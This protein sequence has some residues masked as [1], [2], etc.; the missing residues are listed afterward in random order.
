MANEVAAD[1]HVGS[2]LAGY[3]IEALLGRGGM[4]VVYL[5][6][7]LA[8]GRMVAL[9]L[10][11]PE[12]SKDRRF[13]ERFR[14][15]SRLAASIDHPNVIPIY[16]AGEAEGQLFIAMRYVEGIDLKRL[17]D[18][19]GALESERAVRLLAHIAE[20][21]DAAHARGL[22]HRDV[23]PSNVLLTTQADREHVYLADFGLTKTSASAEDAAQTAHLSGTTDYVAPEQIRDGT[24]G[25]AADVYALGCLFYESLTGRVPYPR[26]SEFETLW[27]HVD[28]PPPKPSEI[29]PELSSAFDRVVATALA[30]DPAERYASGAEL[31]SAARMALP[32]GT[33][34]GHRA[35]VLAVAVLAA[36]VAATVVVVRG[37]DEASTTAPTLELPGPALQRVDPDDLHLAAT[38]K[39]G[40]AVVVRGEQERAEPV[41]V[42]FG[43]GGVW[44]ASGTGPSF[45]RFDPETSE[46]T[47]GR[48]MD[49]IE[50]GIAVGPTSVWL[51]THG[52]EGEGLLVQLDPEQA[53]AGATIDLR[54]LASRAGG[55]TPAPVNVI[56]AV[57]A[58]PA[59]ADSAGFAGWVADVAE[60]SLRQLRRDQAGSR[61]DA[62]ETEGTPLALAVRDDVLWVAQKGEVL[63]VR[64][65]RSGDHRVASRTPVAGTPVA[66]AAGKDG[67]WVVSRQGDLSRIRLGGG[68]AVAVE[69][70]GRSVDLEL[71]DESLWLLLQDGRLLR[72][73]PRSGAMLGSVKVGNNP[74]ALAVGGG[75]IWVA[76]Q[77]GDRRR[78]LPRQYRTVSGEDLIPG[79]CSP[80]RTRCLVALFR[81]LRAGDGTRGIFEAAW[82][83]HRVAGGSIRC[84]GKRYRGPVTA[85]VRN[86][87]TGKMRIVGWGTLALRLERWVSASS[88]SEVAA[89]GPLCGVATGTWLGTTGVLKGAEGRFTFIRREPREERIVL[90]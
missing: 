63:Q 87:G 3:R 70:M 58:D 42:A 84:E 29:R 36:T 2:E 68:V 59:F 56:G 19:E 73:D 22:V 57:I 8:L 14:L 78:D 89:G 23:K 77:G 69:A 81:E 25:A 54:E 12:L 65:D 41:D 85:D 62:I 46:L 60:G 55:P 64:I 66:V 10:L 1:P 5:A 49:G 30:K 76:V 15:E 51:V 32:A 61:Y 31:A 50:A 43:H 38:M 20:G 21:L 39:I 67:A 11:A 33:R 6:E 74:A 13:R 18:Q 4:S 83:T 28:E 48:A 72:L 17:L 90:R 16:E 40:A 79:A 82:R 9:K 24:A 34:L 80:G 53:S 35:V 45:Y 7:D 71:A 75:A 26:A 86:P 27:A 88:T 44:L 47:E 52:L 37:G